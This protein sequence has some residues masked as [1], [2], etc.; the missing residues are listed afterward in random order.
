MLS[1][2]PVPHEWIA[3]NA[4]VNNL[5]VNNSIQRRTKDIIAILSY[6]HYNLP[7]ICLSPFSNCRSHF[8]LDRLGKC[9]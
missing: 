3:F 1:Y 5:F 4:T 2:L 7:K 9:L 6:L 8:L